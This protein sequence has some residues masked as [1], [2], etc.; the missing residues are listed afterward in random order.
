MSKNLKIT[1]LT[2]EFYSYGALLIAGM[3][4]KQGYPVKLQ[5]GFG[6]IID[7]DMFLSAYNPPFIS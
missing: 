5:K 6:E 3:L 7:A 1:V 4:E 2:P